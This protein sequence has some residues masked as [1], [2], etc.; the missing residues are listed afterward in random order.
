MNYFYDVSDERSEEIRIYWD[1]NNNNEEEENT[2]IKLDMNFVQTESEEAACLTLKE[3]A[4][5][6]SRC[7]G[8]CFD[9][10]YEQLEYDFD[11]DSMIMSSDASLI[12]YFMFKNMQC[13]SN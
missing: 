4:D 9:N 2:I 6:I 8:E 7:E 10:C 13:P 11:H 3:R 1:Q 12:E 5:W